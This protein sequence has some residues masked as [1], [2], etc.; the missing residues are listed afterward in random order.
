M[1]FFYAS[2]FVLLAAS[3]WGFENN[4]T[5]KIAS[6]STYDIVTLKGIFS[7]LGSLV[8]ALF[9]CEQIS[10]MLYIALMLLLGFVA[11]GLSIFMY[12]NAQRILSVAKTSAYYAEAPFIGA[13]LS[14]VFLNEQ[15]RE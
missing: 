13:F 9:L 6:K 11:Y 2:L 7:G 15:L 8:I 12:V 14:F 3:Y 10:Q 1:K 5:R 4:C